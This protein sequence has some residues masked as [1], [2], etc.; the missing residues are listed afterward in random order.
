MHHSE[1]CDCT[2]QIIDRDEHGVMKMRAQHGVVRVKEPPL[3][4]YTGPLA[5]KTYHKIAD[6]FERLYS[7]SK[8]KQL[9]RFAQKIVD[10]SHIGPDLKAFALCWKASCE[11]FLCEQYEDGEELLRDAWKKASPI[12]CKNGL[13]LQGMICRLFAAISYNRGKYDEALDHI[14]A[15]KA[16]LWNAAP[17][18]ETALVLYR[19]TVVKWRELVM[20]KVTSANEY[21]SIEK[22][23]DNLLEHA[24][25]VKKYEKLYIFLFRMEKA[26]FHLRT[27]L[28]SDMLPPDEFRPTNLDLEKAKKCLD[29]VSLDKLLS[30]ASFYAVNYYNAH[31]DLCLWNKQ[32]PEAMA[33]VKKAKQLFPHEKNET[34]TTRRFNERLKLLERHEEINKILKNLDS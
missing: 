19:E 4:K 22:D 17:S 30:E 27:L 24:K 29:G 34:L 32:Y 26:K 31:C 33:Y 10:S 28:I 1:G 25:Y 5:T 23:F 9:K 14:D 2:V 12:E 11:I 13:L 18:K 6:H 7:P 16:R 20:L 3:L 21:K 8:Y 15:A